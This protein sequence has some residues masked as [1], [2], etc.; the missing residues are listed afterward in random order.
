MNSIR[1]QVLNEIQTEIS[2][3]GVGDSDVLPQTSDTVLGN[4][5][6]R[7]ALLSQSITGNVYSALIFMDVTENNGNNIL[8]QG[9]FNA[10]AAGDMFNRSLTNLIV[11]DANTEVTIELSITVEVINV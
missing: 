8:E 11:K 3:L 6:Y 1:T 4:E 7:D 2:H 10:A 5:T 9:S